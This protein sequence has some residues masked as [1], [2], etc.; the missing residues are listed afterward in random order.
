MYPN[1]FPCLWLP[2]IKLLPKKKKH[3]KTKTI[4]PS[5]VDSVQYWFYFLSDDLN[6]SCCIISA[7]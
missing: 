4:N 5:D 3:K 1:S 7:K 6:V 2:L